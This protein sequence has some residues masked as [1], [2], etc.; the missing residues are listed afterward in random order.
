MTSLTSAM[1]WRI[2]L[3]TLMTIIS[4]AIMIKLALIAVALMI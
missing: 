3:L 1:L 4:R 2:M